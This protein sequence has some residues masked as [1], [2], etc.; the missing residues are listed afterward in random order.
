[1]TPN[2]LFILTPYYFHQLCLCFCLCN[3]MSG[4]KKTLRS[5]AEAFS[6][7]KRTHS[8]TGSSSRADS[9]LDMSS[10]PRS[11]SASQPEHHILLQERHIKLR[12]THEKD[13]MRLYKDRPSEPRHRAWEDQTSYDPPTPEEN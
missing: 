8:Q 11:S 4:L 13:M 7:R 12:T 5:A 10:M 9:D 6:F 3:R 2:Y 1:M